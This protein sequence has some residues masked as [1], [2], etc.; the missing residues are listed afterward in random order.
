[1]AAIRD[2]SSLAN[3]RVE[4][5]TY[6]AGDTYERLRRKRT[7]SLRISITL[8]TV[9]EFAVIIGLVRRGSRTEDFPFSLRAWSRQAS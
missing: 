7:V 8:L 1:M 4:T 9:T 2:Q 6:R 3:L 5:H